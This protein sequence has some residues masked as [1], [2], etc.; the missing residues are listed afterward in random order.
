VGVDVEL[1]AAF[2]L[3]VTDLV[4]R[5][6]YMALR[7]V[8]SSKIDAAGRDH[9]GDT[10]ASAVIGLMQFDETS[11]PV[12]RRMRGVFAAAAPTV[13][14]KSSLSFWASQNQVRLKPGYSARWSICEASATETDRCQRQMVQRR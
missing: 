4:S 7:R 10:S 13:T 8:P 5:A 2:H 3:E 9:F 11:T 1:A 12:S 6:E 14:G